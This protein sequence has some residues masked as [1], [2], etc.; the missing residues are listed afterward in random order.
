MHKLIAALCFALAMAPAMAQ[1]KGKSD[2]KKVA[3]AA[4]KAKKEPSE[5][6]KAQQERMKDCSGKAGDR[7]GDDRKKYMKD[8]LKVE[9]AAAPDK[10]KAQQNKMTSCN[11]EAGDKKLAGEERKTFMN[12]CLKG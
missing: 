4:E 5:K 6:Q 3:P 11:K 12:A 1:D 8:C 7:K 10:Q 9:P 2:E